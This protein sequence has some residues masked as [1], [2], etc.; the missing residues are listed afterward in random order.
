MKTLTKILGLTLLAFWLGGCHNSSSLYHWGYYEGLIYSNYAEPGRYS[1]EEQIQRLE[2]DLNKAQSQGLK[3]PPGFY[4]HLGYMYHLA[5]EETK[6]IAAF[7]EERQK[8]PESQ[9]F[10]KDIQSRLIQKEA[11]PSPSISSATKVPAQ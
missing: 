7:N 11:K 3:N 6:A 10:M 5:G 9:H 4:A 1:P 8:F 2:Q